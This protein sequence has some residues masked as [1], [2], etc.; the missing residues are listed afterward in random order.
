MIVF[1]MIM[2]VCDLMN[3]LSGCRVVIMIRIGIRIL[4]E[5]VILVGIFF[6]K[7]IVILCCFNVV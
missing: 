2:L 3:K 4:K 1:G 7:W 6:G 5:C